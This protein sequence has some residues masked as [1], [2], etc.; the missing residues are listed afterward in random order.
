MCLPG[1]PAIEKLEALGV[2]RLSM[3]PFLHRKTYAYVAEL[4]KK[5]IDQK[6]LKYIL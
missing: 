5:V 1:L 3:G 6:D 4:A 2:R